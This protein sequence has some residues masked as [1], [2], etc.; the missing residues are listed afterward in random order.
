MQIGTYQWCGSRSGASSGAGGCSRLGGSL[1]NGKHKY[2]SG[3]C[4]VRCQNGTDLF[5]A[6]GD[7]GARPG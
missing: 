3:E 5:L 6:S 1:T 4:R 2:S 7:M